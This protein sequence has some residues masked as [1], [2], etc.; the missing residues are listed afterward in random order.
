MSLKKKTICAILAL[1]VGGLPAVDVLAARRPVRDRQADTEEAKME[2]KA[3]DMINKGLERLKMKQEDAGLKLIS[4]VPEMF[5]KSQARFRAYLEI[6]RYHMEKRAFELAIKQFS[7]L[8]DAEDP[9]QA[10]EGL[11]L[12]GICYYSLNNYDKAFMSLRKVANEYPWSI[13]ANEAYYYIGLCHFK[14]GRWSKVIDA[15]EMVGTSVPANVE[16]PQFAEAGQR[17]YVKIFD[18]DL[19]VQLKKNEKITVDLSTAN[20]DKEKVELEPLGKSGE[21]LIGSIPTEPGNAKP[22]DGVLQTVG[23]DTVTVEYVDTNTESG[24]LNQLLVGK[25]EMVSTA[26]V[27]FTDG[28]YREYTKGVFGDQEA[29]IR[30]KDLDRDVSDEPDTVTVRVHSEYKVERNQEEPMTIAEQIVAEEDEERWEIRDT[31]NVTLKE[32]GPHTGIFVG[33]VTPVV[34]A[35]EAT[36]G[37]D[38][39]EVVKGDEIVVTYIDDHHLVD[40]EVRQTDARAK[41]LI[42]KIQDVA[43]ENRIVPTEELL[44][45]KNLIEA[46]IFL[47]L[48]QI[49]KEV[50]LIQQAGAKAE[51]GLRRVDEVIATSLK[52]SL[53]RSIV[54]ESFSVK[55]DLLLVQDKLGEAIAVCR[56]LTQLF[57]DSSLVDQAL[58]KI[59]IAKMDTEHPAEAIEVFSSVIN[60]PKS[61]LKAEAQYHIGLVHERIALRDAEVNRR[62]PNLSNAILAYT[63]CAEVYPESPFA[64]EALD[65]IA[66]YYI[67]AKDY[68]RAIELMERVFQDY[69]DASFLDKML[70][71]WVI[72]AYRMGNLPV[73]KEKAEQL[74]AEY[75]NSKQAE[76]ARKFLEVI[77]KRM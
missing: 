21:Y 59:G 66:N 75:P 36:P 57:P 63:R 32:T 25:I 44:A 18:K 54:E 6:G 70:L 65:K 74:L 35:T 60:L 7:Y 64:G 4:S 30:V 48:G 42:G 2:Y 69:P 39:L 46:K 13:F 10:A 76:N 68:A 53:D 49:F 14:L 15:M 72:A 27:G 5:P 51:E 41:V 3:N 31:V 26:S 61:D 52:A 50:G 17:L 9:D 24:K 62:E 11:Y 58:L 77:E 40:R 45:R 33:T 47:K 29:F 28:A 37:D 71:K 22:G 23:R 55:W 20:N 73:A 38:R 34:I 56:T 43:V 67:N 8:A 1:A 12:T 19:I 16:G